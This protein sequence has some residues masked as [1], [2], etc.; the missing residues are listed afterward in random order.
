MRR[1]L[2]FKFYKFFAYNF[3]KLYIIINRYLGRNN[4][5]K[6]CK[7]KHNRITLKNVYEKVII[8]K[9]CNSRYK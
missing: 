4:I 6:Q 7:K 8:A 3:S 1:Y 2:K 5:V 9:I